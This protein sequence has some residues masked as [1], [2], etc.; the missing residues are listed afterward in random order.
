MTNLNLVNGENLVGT[1]D[2]LI[3]ERGRF[4]I[5]I[6]S[7]AEVEWVAALA[8]FDEEDIVYDDMVECTNIWAEKLS[9]F[10]FDF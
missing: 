5:G 9:N 8:A 7:I 3:V 4:K 2:Y 1:K 10:L 6:I